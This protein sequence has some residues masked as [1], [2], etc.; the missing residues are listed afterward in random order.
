MEAPRALRSESLD[1]EVRAAGGLVWRHRSDGQLEVL[2]V[3]RPKYDDWA[4][5]KGKAEAAESYKDCAL[6]EVEEETGLA[7]QLG[8]ELP[9]T[10]YLDQ[11]RRRKLVRYW[12]MQ[13][14]SGQFVP[15]KEIDEVRWLLTEEALDLL[16]YTRDR[17]IL[18]RIP[19]HPILL[20]IFN[21]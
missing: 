13:P 7:C 16:S 18:R 11:K 1:V 4:F 14:L 12:A 3:H 9:S 5:P 19:C 15:D 10:T 21:L 8:D 2:L 20:I 17:E 6:R